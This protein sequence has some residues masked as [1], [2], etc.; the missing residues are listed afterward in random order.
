MPIFQ[1]HVRDPFGLIVDEEGIELPDLAAVLRE[2]I[3]CSGEFLAE[4]S[5]PTDMLFEITDEADRIVLMLPI[6][7]YPETVSE[8]GAPANPPVEA[9]PLPGTGAPSGL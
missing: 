4:A 3:A 8:I 5:A 9:R 6:R 7:P 1:F 2:A